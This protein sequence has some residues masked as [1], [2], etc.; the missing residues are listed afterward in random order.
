MSEFE[1]E[2]RKFEIEKGMVM[3]P[4]PHKKLKLYADVNLPE[5]LIQELRAAGLVVYSA[6]QTGKSQA[7]PDQ[8]I[9]EEARRQ[10]L[11]LLT[12]DRDFWNDK[13]HPLHWTSGII[14][15]DISPDQPEKACDGLARFYALFAREYPL[16][17]WKGIKA[18]VCEH[19]F[20]LRMH[21][22]EGRVSE[23]E[24]RLNCTGQLMT[25]TLR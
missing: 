5:P 1:R 10:G 16:A 8:S 2:W 20:V 14:F 15:V 23:E 17:W 21:T 12:M 11:V 7:R 4:G 18:R 13:E 19:G 6:R 22:W 9:F 24:F 25:R 3:P